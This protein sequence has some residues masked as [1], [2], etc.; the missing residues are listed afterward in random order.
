MPQYIGLRFPLDTDLKAFSRFLWQQRIPHRIA[1]EQGDQVLWVGS[2]AHADLVKELFE[3]MQCGELVLPEPT[4]L[5]PQIS[6]IGRVLA[7]PVVATLLMLSCLGALLPWLESG[8]DWLSQLTFYPFSPETGR[9]E[10]VWPLAQPWRVVGPMFLHFGLLHIAFNGLW[11]WLL[12]GMI[13]QRQGGLRLLGIVLLV[14]AASNIAQAMVSV[15][16]FGGMSGVIYGLL[17]Y[18]LAWNR[19]RPYQQFPLQPALAWLMIGWL[20]LCMLGL[21]TALGLGEIANTAHAS[22][23]VMGLIL[24]TCA[25]LLDAKPASGP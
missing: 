7:N 10:A 13:E 2:S 24:G 22:G 23:L 12:G 18:I 3:R 6:L 17:G 5:L 19:L 21:V 4:G 15:A 1:E 20:L 11:L 14:G 8:R 16:L 9:V 25:A